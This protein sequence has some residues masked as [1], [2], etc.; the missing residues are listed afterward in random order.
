MP[1]P[2][3][4]RCGHRQEVEMADGKAELAA[5]YLH[6]PLRGPVR[7]ARVLPDL[8]RRRDHGLEHRLEQRPIS[9]AELPVARLDGHLVPHPL[10][11]LGEMEWRVR[12]EGGAKSFV[13][14]LVR[15]EPVA[16]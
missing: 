7:Q 9:R 8:T 5:R 10:E 11:P 16:D 12:A 15:E 3:S 1:A 6:A 4:R 14:A 13:G 2:P